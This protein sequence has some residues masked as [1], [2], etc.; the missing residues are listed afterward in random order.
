MRK[1]EIFERVKKLTQ[2]G[3]KIAA[4]EMAVEA[5]ASENILL[6]RV[7]KLE[8]KPYIEKK[9]SSSPEKKDEEPQEEIQEP[10]QSDESDFTESELETQQ[11][12]DIDRHLSKL[13]KVEPQK[14]RSIF[15]KLTGADKDKKTVKEPAKGVL[16]PVPRP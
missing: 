9:G 7:S 11:D 14:R 10:E 13:Q 1:E 5:L 6:R 12:D 15:A 8:E 16:P 2:S 4:L 3:E